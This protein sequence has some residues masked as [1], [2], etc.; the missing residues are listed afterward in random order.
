MAVVNGP[1]QV[2]VSGGLDEL[3]VFVARCEAEGVQVRRVAVDYASHSP[4]VEELRAEL[5]EVLSGIRPRSGEVPLV[6]TVSGEVIDTAV[7]DAEYWFTNLRQTVRFDQALQTL[8]DAGHR[9]FVE[10]SPHP[11]LLGAVTQNADHKGV[12]GVTAVGTLRRNEGGQARLL[13]HAAE[14]FVAGVDVDW[15]A[16]VQGGR[17]VD[18]PTYAFQHRRYWQPATTGAD[19]GTVGLDTVRHPFLGAAVRLADSDDLVLTGRISLGTHPWLADHAVFGTVIL[20]GTAFVEMALRAAD[21]ADCSGVRDLTLHAPL[22]LPEHGEIDVQVQVGTADATG[23]PVDVYS[24][25]H[26]TREWTHHA[27]GVL[28]EEPAAPPEHTGPLHGTAWPPAEAPR[29]DPAA[30][31]DTLAEA[32]L[33]YGPAFQG[34]SDVWRSGDEVLAQVTLPGRQAEDAARFALHPAL[35]DAALQAAAVHGMEGRDGRT[36]LPFSFGEVTLYGR[37]ASEVRV[38]LT[39]TGPDTFTVEAADPTGAPVARID[40]LLV[41]AVTA[42]DLTLPDSSTQALLSVE[43]TETELARAADGDTTAPQPTLLKVTDAGPAGPDAE[44]A[45]T[46]VRR[47]LH[48]TLRR[49]QEWL[50]QDRPAGERLVVVTRGAVL[51]GA[52]EEGTQPD[53]AHA[54]VWGLVRAARAENPGRVVLV[55]VDTDGTCDVRDAARSGLPES[56]IRSGRSYVPVLRRQANDPAGD[57]LDALGTGTV[58]ITGGTSGLGARVARHAARLGARHLL[59]LSRRG[60]EAEGAEAL[61]EELTAAGARVTVRAC[62]VADRDQLAQALREVPEQYPLTAVIHSAG[63]LHDGVIE[64]VDADGLDTVLRPKTDAAWHLHELTAGEELSAFVVFSSVAGVLGG[65]GQGSYA[66]ANA[67]LDALMQHRRRAG[68]PGLSLAWGLW[69]EATGMTGHLG[70]THLER[71]NRGGITPLGTEQ[72]LALLDAALTRHAS[73]GATGHAVLVA[74]ALNLPVLRTTEPALLPP[75]LAALVPARRRAAVPRSG[76]RAGAAGPVVPANREAVVQ[77]LRYRFARTMGFGTEELDPAASLVGQGLDSVMA[78]QIRSLVEADF[79]QTLPVATMFNGATVE[80]IA[81]HLL[82]GAAGSAGTAGTAPADNAT[83]AD[84]VVAD[85]ERHPATRDV[86]R[87]LRAEQHGTPSV[88]HHIGLAVRL[89]A[90]T[91][92]DRLT[93]AVSRLAGRHAAL[94]TAIVADTGGGQ[95]LE[96]RRAPTDELVR[97]SAVE[98]G[99]DVDERLCALMEPPFDLGRSPLWRFELLAYPSGDQVLVYGAHHAVSDLASLML[100]AHELG[101]ELG[102]QVPPAVVTNRDIDLLLHAQAPA[103]QAP[104]SPTGEREATADW[105]DDFAGVRRLDLELARPRPAQRSYRSAMYL[106]ELPPEL[107]RRVAARATGLGVTPAAFWLGALTL[108]LSRLRGSDRFVLAVPV[109]TRMH[110]GALD[111]VGYFGLPIPYA[112]QVEPG[113]TGTDLLRRTD[114]R[115]SRVLERG[116]SFFDAMPALVEEGLYRKDAPL[117]EVYFNYMPPQAG[118][119]E[120]LRVLPAGTGYSDLDLMITVMPGLGKV[121]LEYNADILDEPSCAALAS[122]VLAVAAE[123]ADDPDATVAVAAGRTD[124]TDAGVA[125]TPAPSDAAASGTVPVPGPRHAPDTTPGP[126]APAGHDAPAPHGAPAMART[127]QGDTAAHGVRPGGQIAVAATFA[128]GNLPALL[129]VALEEADVEGG[130]FDVVEAPYHQ[131]LAALHDPDGVLAQS[132]TAAALVLL[133]PGDLIRFAPEDTGLLD[134]LAEEYPAALRAL[135]DRTRTALVVAFLPERTQDERLRAWERQVTEQ[136]ADQPGIAVLSADSWAGDLA[137]D[138]E[139]APGGVDDIFDPHTDELAHLPFQEEFQAVVALRLADVVWKIRRRA[140]KVIV[141]DGDETLWSGI[142]GEIGPENVDLT[143]PRALLARRLLQWRAA[144][145]LLAMVSNNDEET[146]HGILDRPDSL[147]HREHFAAISAAWEP[148]WTRIVRI[149]E[150]LGLGLDSFLFLDDNPVEIAGVRAQLPEVLSLTC[151]P[152]AEL[153]DFVTRLWPMVPRAATTE[154]AGRAEFYQQERVRDAARAQMGFVEFLENLRLELDIEPVSADTAERTVQLSRRTNQFN[155]RPLPLDTDRL[156]RLQ[157]EGEVWTATARDRFG[158]YGQIGVLAVRPDGDVLEVVAWMMSCRVLGRGVED[159]LLTWLA[160]RADALGC[161]RVRLVADNTPRNI[162]ARRLVSRL[163]GGEVD[164]P[165]L[166]TEVAPA[167]LREF[168]SWDLGSETAAEVSNA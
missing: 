20:P 142:A 117:V 152:A 161:A 164:A 68:R 111:A 138:G 91:T 115:L 2:V 61:R 141:V 41:R 110:V 59:L 85:V 60:P 24:R 129:G 25:Q 83:T 21:E 97:W 94:R 88:T 23:R 26:G 162:P 131:V 146:V 119:A 73:T 95:L 66:A 81:D 37:G 40:S 154:D 105:R 43:W 89:D 155:L 19:V 32:G 109:D 104:G 118:A 106:A 116:V 140:P 72:G 86:V 6:S 122:A 136:L 113:D 76:A 121:G 45:P 65:S 167:Q 101:A 38:R 166:E 63:V 15:S 103:D 120:G 12:Q 100:V 148:K 36:P 1:E 35:L 160:D 165:R 159:R 71:I 33:E 102:G 151:P 53:L 79:G 137:A 17:L 16:W 123:L 44:D 10:A 139:A 82:A 7:M 128:L 132:A 11:V 70:E 78:M 77:R 30:H 125:A 124:S 112:A 8:L 58:L 56:A 147:L 22:S 54:A 84:T 168:R 133:R 5:L 156:E 96:V 57:A 46:R 31:Y 9:V 163:G 67:F 145:V 144:G 107:A 27:S 127:E 55:D 153:E 39:P 80:S 130:P 4:Q 99:T 3:D 51:T 98:D 108:H 93:E 157:Q 50:A 134:Q 14:V 92:P 87:L 149:A 90:P 47:V 34:L 29:L 42:D 49:L 64:S 74:A 126:D 52:E 48:E 114:G 143:G 75:L 62:D 158:A 69:A 18:L 13:Q 28:V 150:Q 135:A